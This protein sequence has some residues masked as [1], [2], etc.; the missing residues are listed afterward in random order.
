MDKKHTESRDVSENRKEF[1]PF[2]E[3]LSS[4]VSEE[5]HKAAKNVNGISWF[6][7]SVATDIRQPRLWY[8]KNFET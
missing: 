6:G 4:Q 8:W 5:F 2:C 3:N 7:I 1:V